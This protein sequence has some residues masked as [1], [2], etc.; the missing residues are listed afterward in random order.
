MKRPSWWLSYVLTSCC[1]AFSAGGKYGGNGAFR[2]NA[3]ANV[4]KYNMML[5]TISRR[6]LLTGMMKSRRTVYQNFS[7]PCHNISVPSYRI[8]VQTR[9]SAAAHGPN[10]R[11]KRTIPPA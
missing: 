9:T 8:P 4:E 2:R 5:P 3:D 1:L 11:F 7:I 10:W 6:S